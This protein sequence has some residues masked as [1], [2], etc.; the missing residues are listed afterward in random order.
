MVALRQGVGPGIV[1]SLVEFVF[2]L[3]VFEEKRGLVDATIAPRDHLHRLKAGSKHRK[4]AAFNCLRYTDLDESS[5]LEV[6]TACSKAF[7]KATSYRCA[8]TRQCSVD[9][10]IN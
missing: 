2:V 8:V 4:R 3:Q 9:R 1:E 7:E 10:H 6:D 5:S